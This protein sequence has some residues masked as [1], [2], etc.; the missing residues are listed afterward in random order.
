MS[1]YEVVVKALRERW[2]GIV[3]NESDQF[4]RVHRF[5]GRGEE[6]GHH[7]VWVWDRGGVVDVE[8][9][10]KAGSFTRSFN[11][12]DPDLFDKIDEWSLVKDWT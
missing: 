7:S 12:S 2:G 1:P 3:M 9:S 8:V 6:E 4:G 11:V 10:H 5:T